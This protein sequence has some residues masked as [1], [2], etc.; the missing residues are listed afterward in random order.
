M[1]VDPDQNIAKVHLTAATRGEH[2]KVW[3]ATEYGYRFSGRLEVFAVSGDLALVRPLGNLDLSQLSR[4]TLVAR[5][6]D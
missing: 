4:G 3:S 6:A 2:L 5:A 1:V